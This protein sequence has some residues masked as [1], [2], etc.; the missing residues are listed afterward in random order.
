MIIKVYKTKEGAKNRAKK[1]NANLKMR[2][3]KGRKAHVKTYKKGKA[4]RFMSATH[5]Y[6]VAMTVK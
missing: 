2:K 1:I 6:A 5:P 4:H 3:I